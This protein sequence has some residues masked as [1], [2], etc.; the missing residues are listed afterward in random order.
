M[1]N[2][3]GVASLGRAFAYAGSTNQL[4]SLWPVNDNSTQ[5]IMMFYYEN[6]K[7]GVGK[8]TAL[9]K[10]K[11]QFLESAPEALQHPYYWAGLVYYGEDTPLRLS[12]GYGWVYYALG[13]LVLLLIFFYLLKR[14]KSKSLEF[15]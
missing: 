1:Q 15:S 8:A 4:V 10:A 6:L 2:G 12:S 7:E 9:F 5:E 3:E 14:K 13:L 11:K